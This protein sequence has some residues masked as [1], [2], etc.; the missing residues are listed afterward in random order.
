[1]T[2]VPANLAGSSDPPAFYDAISDYRRYLGNDLWVDP[3]AYN[4]P[5]LNEFGHFSSPVTF[6]MARVFFGKEG[7]GFE[8]A[9]F[10]LSHFDLRM[11]RLM[12]VRLVATDASALSDGALLYEAKAGNRDVRIFRLDHVNLG[13]YSPTRFRLVRSASDAIAVMKSQDFDPSAEAVV[14]S[15][16]SP[17]LRPA[18]SALVMVDRGPALVVRATSPAHS[19]LVLPFEYSRCL[20]MTITAGHAQLIPVNL[21]QT[22][23]LFDG[24]LEARIVYRF[25]LLQHSHCRSED[26]QRAD[27]LNLKEA[28][29]R[30]QR[31]TIIRER[32]KLGATRHEPRD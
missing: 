11:A 26:Q 29:L 28:L 6:A 20:S 16:I 7:D 2:I 18:S 21:Q 31:A 3:L 32:P 5:M 15:S 19:L 13:Q 17:E 9:T 12:G 8:R 22:G 1:M 25:G 24:E 4:I 10:V 14:E 27:D 30:Y 23:L